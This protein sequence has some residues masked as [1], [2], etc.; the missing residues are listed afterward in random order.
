[1]SP[2]EL[3]ER[4]QALGIG[5]V[6]VTEH[7]NMWDLHEV[8]DLAGATGVLILRGMEVT[9]DLG[10][11]GVFGLERYVGGIYRLAELR[12]VADAEAESCRKPSFSLQA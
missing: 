9:T 3:I 2:K 1:M 5:A 4:A 11:V 7:D 10:H 12:R 8:A 6:C